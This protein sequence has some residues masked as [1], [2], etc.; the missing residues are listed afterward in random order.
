M[1]RE[2]GI[3]LNQVDSQAWSRFQSV[4]EGLAERFDIMGASQN[5]FLTKNADMLFR[6]VQLLKKSTKT[7]IKLY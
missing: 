6:K 7:K 2:N 1:L 4:L 5:M 3:E